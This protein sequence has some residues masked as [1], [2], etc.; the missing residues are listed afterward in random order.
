MPERWPPPQHRQKSQGEQCDLARRAASSRAH[1][2]SQK[3]NPARVIPRL[4]SLREIGRPPP[5][6]AGCVRLLGRGLPDR[7]ASGLASGLRAGA[8]SSEAGYGGVR[9]F[10]SWLRMGAPGSGLRVGL[11]Q[12]QDWTEAGAGRDPFS[13][14]LVSELEIGTEQLQNWN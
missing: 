2:V 9:P 3:Q 5:G 12:A 11:N 6:S 13:P 7:C 1:L 8:S 10:G 4:M 14:K